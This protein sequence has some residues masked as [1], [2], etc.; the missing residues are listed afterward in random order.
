MWKVVLGVDNETRKTFYYVV[1]AKVSAV[2]FGKRK[3]SY[4]CTIPWQLK[5]LG[6]VGPVFKTEI[7]ARLFADK[8]NEALR[9]QK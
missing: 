5:G 6:P 1:P 9:K 3:I 8:K 2:A 4:K 7:D